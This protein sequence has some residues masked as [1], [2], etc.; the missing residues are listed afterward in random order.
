MAN[1]SLHLARSR[2]VA[3]ACYASAL[4]GTARHIELLTEGPAAQ[5]GTYPGSCRGRR[6]SGQTRRRWF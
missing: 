1:R 5:P 3:T 6:V 4:P 2:R